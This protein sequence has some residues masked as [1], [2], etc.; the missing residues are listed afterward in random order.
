VNDRDPDPVRPLT[1]VRVLAIENFLA[2]PY[3]SM[4]L[5][6]YGADV[7]K[8]ESAQGDFFRS[9]PP[10]YSNGSDEMSWRFLRINRNKRSIV[11]DLRS[12]EGRG[13]FLSLTERCDVVWENLRPGALDRLKLGWPVLQARNPRLIYASVSGFGHQDILPNPLSHRPG[14]D[15]V[16]QAMAGLAWQAGR[17]GDPPTYYG[18][19]LADQF[20]G[21]MAAFGVVLALQHRNLTGKGQHV[22]LAMYDCML[23]L[24]ELEAGYYGHFGELSGRGVG[25]IGPFQFFK[26]SD[27]WFSVGVSGDVVWKRFCEVIGRM[28][29]YARED[30]GDGNRRARVTESLFRPLLEE[31]AAD[32]TVAD[33]CERFNAAGVPSGPVQT[34]PE[35]FNCPQA[36]ARKMLIVQPDPAAGPTTLVGNAVK[37]S[38]V[39]EIDVEPSPRLGADTDAV[40]KEVLGL[41]DAEIAALRE[42]RVAGRATGT[43]TER[44]E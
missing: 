19:S 18:I 31:W 33:I 4:L 43:T 27:G 29:L 24:N 7:I 2:G 38:E 42:S 14:F 35:I 11:V 23:M 40:L 9:Y 17:E 32:K 3:G 28:D 39:P 1:G 8:V 13:L 30:L 22:D 37:F 26:A 20:T 15:I 41:S 44:T 34:L 36:N 5:A 12:D 16:A 25:T 10:V 6:D 21:T